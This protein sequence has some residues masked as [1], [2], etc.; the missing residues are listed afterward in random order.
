MG[1]ERPP[2]IP[3]QHVRAG[4]RVH[5]LKRVRVAIDSF[6]VPGI[7]RDFVH[8]VDFALLVGIALADPLVVE[9]RPTAIREP[10]VLTDNVVAG[11][12][13]AVQ[14][15]ILHFL[16]DF[17]GLAD[18]CIRQPFRVVFIGREELVAKPTVWLRVP[19][20]AVMEV[21]FAETPQPLLA[22]IVVDVDDSRIS[23]TVGV[24]D[25]IPFGE[26]LRLRHGIQ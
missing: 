9:K 24:E 2:E 18:N 17:F 20:I 13:T 15:S 5:H 23:R 1:D 12:A 21:V 14:F 11:V 7:A 8:R 25:R 4:I 19:N 3:P 10:E 22:V 6:C 26:R 16:H